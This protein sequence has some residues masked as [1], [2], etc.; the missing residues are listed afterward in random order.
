[1]RSVKITQKEF[2]EKVKKLET[3]LNQV[4]I[5]EAQAEASAALSG[6]AFKIGDTGDTFKNVEEILNKK[7]EKAAGKA[8]VAMDLTETEGVKEK[9]SEM[10]ALDQAAL[11]EFLAQKG[12]QVEQPA[13]APE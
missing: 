7:Y 5:K 12:I 10:Q 3:Q 9:E 8:R 6:V 4:K 13:G 2:E 1:V 11:A